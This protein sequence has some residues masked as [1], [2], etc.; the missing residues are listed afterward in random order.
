MTTTSNDTRLLPSTFYKTMAIASVLSAI[1]TLLLIF[2]PRLYGPVSGL[3]ARIGVVSDP[4]YQLRAWIYF[5]HPFLVFGAALAVALRWRRNAPSWLLVGII[6]FA[7]WGVTEAAQQMLTLTVWDPWRKAWLAGNESV[8]ATMALRVE[9][10]DGLWDAMYSLLLV[11][12]AIGNLCFMI[13][14]WRSS[15]LTRVVASF[16]GFAT[17]LTIALF[18]GNFGLPTLSKSITVWVYPL[19]Q[20]F[21]RVVIGVWLW[22]HADEIQP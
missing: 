8:R 14:L 21:A 15:G 22:P 11:G 17:L 3:E 7:L 4:A 6:G 16:Y 19:L 5:I 2:L 13:A 12:F 10:Y 18:L 1:T 9:I 20:P